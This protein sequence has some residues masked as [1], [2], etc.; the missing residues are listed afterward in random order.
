MRSTLVVGLFGLALCAGACSDD[1]DGEGTGGTAGSG[2]T[3]NVSS[4]STGSGGDGSGGDATGATGGQATGGEAAGGDATGGSG[5]G[6]AGEGGA[7][8]GPMQGAF[9]STCTGEGQGDCNA[10]YVCIVF[11]NQ[12]QLCTKECTENA[13]CAPEA[14]MCNNKGYCK[15][16]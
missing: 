14:Q 15:P 11:D 10:P 9:G 1:D 7:G 5:E 13:E 4:S 3:G 16:F 2:N 8:G 12:M 6:G